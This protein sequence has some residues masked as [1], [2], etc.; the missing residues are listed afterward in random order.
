[1]TQQLPVAVQAAFGPAED[2]GYYLLALSALP[3]GLFEVS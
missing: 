3:G 2:G 1:V